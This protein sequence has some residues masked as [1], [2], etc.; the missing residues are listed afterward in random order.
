MQGTTE[1]L[2]T[3]NLAHLL[4]I[5]GLHMGLL[6]GVVFSGLRYVMALSPYVA[7]RVNVKKCAA[8]GA[9]VAAAVYL[10]LSGASIATERAFV[11]A[12]V[13]LV[14]VLLDRRAISMRSVAIAALIVLV[15]RP[16]SLLSPGFHMSFAATTALVWV[17]SMLWAQSRWPGP[18][19]IKPIMAVT[20]TSFVAGAA[21][22]PFAGAHFNG[23]AAYGLPANL[24]AVPIMGAVVMPSAVVAL[25]L[26][27]LGLEGLAL[28]VMGW[29]LQWILGVASFFADLEGARRAVVAPPA[30]VLPLFTLGALFV[31]LWQGR[32]RAVALV[33]V[34]VAGAL[35]LTSTRPDLLVD[36]SGKLAGALTEAGRIVSKPR[37]QGFAA[38]VWLENDGDP[39]E[40]KEAF[41]RADRRDQDHPFAQLGGFDVWVLSKK[42]IQKQSPDCVS[43]DILIAALPIETGLPCTVFDPKTLARTGAL[44]ITVRNGKLVVTSV[45]DRRG[46][47]LWSPPDQRQ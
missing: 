4:A 42:D 9:L 46:D 43:S 6:V 40:Q 35:W 7:L 19:W 28:T 13:A 17:F 33:P 18:A 37:G 30:A 34:I 23:Y 24:L 11:M 15:L 14:A 31:M 26:A 36:E 25:C 5:S 47:R 44:A 38:R 32:L 45:A 3:T 1:D 16:E 29:G 22:A 2:R 8:V 21:T 10:A 20:L 41:A 12:A 39:T 27:P